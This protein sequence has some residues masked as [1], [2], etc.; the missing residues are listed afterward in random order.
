MRRGRHG[1]LGPLSLHKPD[2]RVVADRRAG[3]QQPYLLLREQ[4]PER[5]FRHDVGF[6]GA[7]LDVELH[8]TSML[9]T[10]SWLWTVAIAIYTIA[11][12]SKATTLARQLKPSVTHE[13]NSDKP[14]RRLLAVAAAVEAAVAVAA[15]TARVV[16]AGSA[17]A[18]GL[19]L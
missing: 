19:C 2:N 12:V 13:L 9:N 14:W 17:A 16:A 11:A 5:R 1:G 7:W 4:L 15:V 18:F 6:R 8:L 10:L 3:V